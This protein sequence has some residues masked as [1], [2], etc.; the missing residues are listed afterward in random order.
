MLD[1]PTGDLARVRVLKGWLH[2]LIPSDVSIS[3]MIQPKNAFIGRCQNNRTKMLL[4]RFRRFERTFLV[5]AI[6]SAGH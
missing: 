3:R 1:R 5:T 2:G 6:K 4:I